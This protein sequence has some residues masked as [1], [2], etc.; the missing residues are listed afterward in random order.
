MDRLEELNE[1]LYAQIKRLS[2]EDLTESELDKEI[3]RAKAMAVISSQFIASSTLQ[4][5]KAMMLA[6]G[7]ANLKLLESSNGL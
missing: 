4:M 3:E 6:G 1:V 2:S 5:R 7:Q